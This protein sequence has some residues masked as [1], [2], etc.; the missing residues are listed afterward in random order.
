MHV[1]RLLSRS[2]ERLRRSYG[3]HDRGEAGE[4]AVP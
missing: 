4:G 1:S 2:I 3:D